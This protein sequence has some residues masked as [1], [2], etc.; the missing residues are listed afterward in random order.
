MQIDTAWSVSQTNSLLNHLRTRLMAL[1]DAFVRARR[2]Q[3]DREY[4]LRMTDSRLGDIGLR[5]VRVDGVVDFIPLD[6]VGE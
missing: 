4:L 6:H 5:R 2:N 1:R 3:Q